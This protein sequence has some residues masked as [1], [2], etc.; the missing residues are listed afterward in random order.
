MIAPTSSTG[1]FLSNGYL[2]GIGINFAT[3]SCK[4]IVHT[5]NIVGQRLYYPSVVPYVMTLAPEM[6]SI[7]RIAAADNVLFAIDQDNGLWASGSNNYWVISAT[8]GS[9]DIMPWTKVT[10]PIS[11]GTYITDIA[12]S[13]DVKGVLHLISD[14]S[15]FA[16]GY[17]SYG[18]LGLNDTMN[19]KTPAL[20]N[21]T[22]ND[23]I[24]SVYTARNAE[25]SM[26]L[27]ASGSLYYSGT[28]KKYQVANNTVIFT[29]VVWSSN[30]VSN[31]VLK[32]YVSEIGATFMVFTDGTLWAWGTNDVSLWY[33]STDGNSDKIIDPTS[34][35]QAYDFPQQINLGGE[36]AVQ[37][38]LSAYGYYNFANYYYYAL[39]VVLTR[40][41]YIM[42]WGGPSQRL[43]R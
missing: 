20:V 37:V 13:S 34:S 17:N 26:I 33:T 18:G 12:V 15:L 23:P 5:D 41:G 32:S 14:G 6:S 7:K 43:G 19:R 1:I 25:Y 4:K 9:S 31:K 3:M 39:V 21:M 29:Q 11:V 27:G 22:F 36:D 16:N 24:K 35:T 28:V 40:S 30:P 10:L 2:Y 42:T 8:A 38:R